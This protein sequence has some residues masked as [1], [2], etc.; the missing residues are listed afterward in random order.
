M[1]KNLFVRIFMGLTSSE[2]ASIPLEVVS[3]QRN[4]RRVIS[5]ILFAI[6]LMFIVSALIALFN[7]DRV[8]SMILFLSMMP[9]SLSYFLIRKGRF[10]L[11]VT[12]ISLVL[13]IIITMISTFGLGIHH[14]SNMTYA[15]ILI[16]SSLLVRKRTLIALTLVTLCC[17]AWLVFGELAGLFQPQ[18]FNKSVWGDFFTTAFIIVSNVV[19]AR[20]LIEILLISHKQIGREL[21]RREVV[22]TNLRKSEEKYRSLHESMRDGYVYTDMLGRIKEYNEAYRLM[23]GYEK[24]ELTQLSFY[25]LTPEKWFE[26]EKKIIAEEIIPNGFSH[27]YEKEYQ[28]KDG[29][30]F[31]VEL[32]AYLLKD[33]DGIQQGMWAVVRDIT[34]RK[35]LQDELLEG[36]EH[37]RSLVEQSVDGVIL[38]NEEGLV[39]EWNQALTNITGI[40][41]E[42][43]IGR[44]AWD[45]QYRV[46]PPRH[47]LQTNPEALRD[48]VM[49]ALTDGIIPKFGSSVEFEIVNIMG[50]NRALMQ[51]AFPI[52]TK[53]GYRIGAFIRDLTENVE[54][55]KAERDHRILA[56]ALSSSAAALNSTLDLDAVLERFMDSVGRV[57]PH[58]SIQVFLLDD[59]GTTARLAAFRNFDD[60]NEK[61][62]V[63]EFLVSDTRNL[64]EMQAIKSPAIIFDTHEYNGW[65]INPLTEW[66]RSCLGVP[67]TIKGKIIGFVCLVSAAPNSFNLLDARRLQSF[68]DQSAKAIENARLYAELQKLAINDTLTGVFNRSFFE[69]ELTRLE[70][71]RDFPISIIVAD[72]DNLKLTNDRRGHLAGD[73]LLKSVALILQ[74]TF[75]VEDIIARIG[76]DEFA[77]LLP[78][79]NDTVAEQMMVRIRTRLD[80]YN[81]LHPDS[82]L[83]FSMGVSTADVDNLVEAFNLA[84][85]R[86]YEE[87]ALRKVNDPKK[88][89]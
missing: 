54:A 27:V 45:V 69:T 7:N 67:I 1:F 41:R 75:R 64:R 63:L 26:F 62:S 3:D 33:D 70:H 10:E 56:E 32:R 81:Q 52:K 86:M 24:S 66:V 84:D 47:Q 35:Q 4:V 8:G 16:I 48:M 36:E 74:E 37:F 9:V 89:E 28:R 61:L 71:G 83:Q 68:I 15:L 38:I 23:L 12:F 59:Q 29:T 42:D 53:K 39:E 80:E 31:P 11:A 43:A 2:G 18:P 22:E 14:I 46:L 65:V 58:L 78:N 88:K 44:P 51:S 79:T 17:V 30:I 6:L 49:P 87:K 77:V 21:T 85:R 82:P 34:K 60:Q 55:E 19:I 20:I 25:D 73:L 40:R 57:V 76:G 13:I 50:Q 5:S 72:M